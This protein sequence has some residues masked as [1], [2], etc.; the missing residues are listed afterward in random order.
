MSWIQDQIQRH[1]DTL[2]GAGAETGV[3]VAVYRDGALIV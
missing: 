1:I 2:A 3:Q